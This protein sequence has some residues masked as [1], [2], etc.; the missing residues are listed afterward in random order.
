MIASIWPHLAAVAALLLPIRALRRWMWLYA[1]AVLPGTLAHEL[2]HWTAGWLFGARPVSLSILPRRSPDGELM[3]GRVLFAR[4]RWWNSLPVAL[5]PL[6]L[7]PVSAWMLWRS[8]GWPAIAWPSLALKLLA[9]QCL[10]ATW[11]SGR[12]WRHALAGAA[13]AIA[14]IA[15]GFYVLSWLG[16]APR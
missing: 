6:I 12:D 11:P 1:L 15:A 2:M 8:A 7:L 9:V 10:L 14:L 3:L 5:A 16:F 13:I 4:L